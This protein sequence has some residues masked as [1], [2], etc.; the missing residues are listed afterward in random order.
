M[1]QR[2]R[3][4]SGWSDR[5]AG[6]Q[7]QCRKAFPHVFDETAL[8]IEQVRD[9]ADVE[10]EP[11]AIHLDQGRPAFRPARE[12]LHQSRI[13]DRIGRNRDERGIERPRIGQPRTGPSAAL[14]GGPR[15]GMDDWPVCALDGED[16]R[17]VRRRG[18]GL[19]PALGRQMRQPDG[20]DPRHA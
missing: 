7:A 9:S 10:P 4:C 16:D 8:A 14:G 2:P 20:T 12:P 11:I 13:A 1:R 19:R 15:H 17:C 3:R 6:R 5:D 18:A